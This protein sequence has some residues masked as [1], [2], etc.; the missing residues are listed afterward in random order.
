MAQGA[1][2]A[3]RTE[4][5]R[6]TGGWQNVLG[7]DIVLTYALLQQGLVSSYEPAAVGYTEV[8]QTCNGLYNQRKRWAIGMLEGLSSVPP[9]RQGSAYSLYFT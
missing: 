5:V 4:V 7:E 3:Y 1:F 2:S 6:E 9:W 8:P